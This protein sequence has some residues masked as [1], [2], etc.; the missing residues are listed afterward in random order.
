MLS[1]SNKLRISFIE[2][3]IRELKLDIKQ[4][5][6]AIE[7]S[8]KTKNPVRSLM[9]EHRAFLEILT[10]LKHNVNYILNE[11]KYSLSEKQKEEY[12]ELFY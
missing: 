8:K 5:E 2:S 10:G 1:K 6:Y 3:I 9:G 11:V 7:C 12:D 4:M